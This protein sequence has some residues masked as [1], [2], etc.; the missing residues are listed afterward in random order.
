[1]FLPYPNLEFL[2]IDGHHLCTRPLM[3][4]EPVYLW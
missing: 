2:D 3:K 1:M 4:I